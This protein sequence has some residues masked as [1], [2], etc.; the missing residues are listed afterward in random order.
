MVN[1]TTL[2]RGD[3]VSTDHLRF[4]T[5]IEAFVGFLLI[6]ASGAFLLNILSGKSPLAVSRRGRSE[7]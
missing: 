2:G 5:A 6:T 7:D 1:F 3:L 4:I